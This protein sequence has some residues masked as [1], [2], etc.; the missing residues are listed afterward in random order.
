MTLA[1]YLFIAWLINFVVVLIM[2]RL[3]YARTN[4]YDRF[5]VQ[6][7]NWINTFLITFIL[8]TA[9]MVTYNFARL[10]HLYHLHGRS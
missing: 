1:D 9:F 3:A 6:T 2:I 7:D 8:Q 10:I 4:F 5:S